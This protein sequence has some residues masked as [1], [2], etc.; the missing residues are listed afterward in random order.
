M[1]E[2]NYFDA[3]R[4]DVD[5]S[6]CESLP[7]CPVGME[8]RSAETVATVAEALRLVDQGNGPVLFPSHTS[9]LPITT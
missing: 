1:D 7:R 6:H 3:Q 4:F 5:V 9:L 2:D 8:G